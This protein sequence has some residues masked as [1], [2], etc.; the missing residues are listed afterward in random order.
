M[1]SK[2]TVGVVGTG[3]MGA[4]MAVNLAK[5]GYDVVAYN[6]TPAK[7]EALAGDG[8]R[9]ARSVAE[10]GSAAPIVI[11]MVPDTPD[12]LDV[13]E[14]PGGLA[15]SMAAGSVL[16][17]MSTIAPGATRELSARLAERGI[18]MLD[19][20]VS[21]GSWG[22]QQATLTIM[23]GGEQEVFDRCL[24]VFEAL[25]KSVTLMGPSG[26]GQITKLVNQVL[27]AGTCSAV[28][29][30][31]VFAAAHGADLL[32]TI[33]AVGGGAAASWQLANLGPR[34]VNGDFAPGFM[35]RPPDGNCS[36]PHRP[37]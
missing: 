7:A 37:A 22:A 13:V 12:V 9:V 19:A 4:P 17:D 2:G 6:R 32:K 16:V 1:A 27:V 24:P 11:T 20:P 21:G 18:A 30:A 26:M 8:V 23:A 36:R 14:G 10:V 35:V 31:L 33:E 5:A 34:M 3:I 25:G 15:G 28:A 29:E